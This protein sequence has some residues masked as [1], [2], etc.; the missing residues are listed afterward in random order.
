M[1]RFPEGAPCWAVAMLPD[2]EA[3]KRFYGELLGWSY[4]GSGEERHGYT[5]ATLGGRVVAG[6]L[7]KPDGRMPTDWALHLATEDAQAC[8]RRIR[9]AGGQVI[10]DPF[11]V[12]DVGRTA[13][14]ADPGGAVFQLWESTSMP[15]FEITGRPGAYAWAEVHTRDKEAV[16]A[17]YREV[18]GFGTEDLSGTLGQDFLVWAPAGEPVD[19]AHAIGGRA[20]LEESAPE[21]LPAHFLTYFAVRNCDEAVQVTARLG[22]RTLIGPQDTPYGRVASLVDNQGAYFAVIAEPDE[23]EPDEGE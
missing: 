6:L 7:A 22:G 20:V 15:G 23:G 19:D 13:V 11:P 1:A 10:M 14:A 16:D 2:L 18:F 9:E 21:E 3:G 4:G 5:T 8:A 12:G 17:F